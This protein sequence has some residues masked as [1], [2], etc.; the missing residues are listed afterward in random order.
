MGANVY[1]K[2]VE[3][4]KSTVWISTNKILPKGLIGHESDT[5][6]IK[7]GDG[8]S[9]WNDLP[10]ISGGSGGAIASCFDITIDGDLTPSETVNFDN[11]WEEDSNGDYQPKA[12]I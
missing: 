10:Y 3:S 12:V 1:R 11:S 7:V 6:K 4:N 5:N 9:R 8:A 2:D